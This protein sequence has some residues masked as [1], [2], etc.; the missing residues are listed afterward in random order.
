MKDKEKQINEMAN[1]I[2]DNHGFIVSSVE[3]AIA[4]YK[5]G[6][7]KLPEDYEKY[8]FV[9]ISRCNGKD[10]RSLTDSDVFELLNIVAKDT[11]KETAEKIMVLRGY[12][13]KQFHKYHEYDFQD[14]L[15]CIH[16]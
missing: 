5:A 9:K 7:R 14:V 8:C 1:I 4:L 16:L 15:G 11:K 6:Y 13:T 2:D 10:K 3:T 12:I